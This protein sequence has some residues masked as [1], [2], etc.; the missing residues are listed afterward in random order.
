MGQNLCVG[1]PELK[2]KVKYDENMPRKQKKYKINSNLKSMT[3]QENSQ[4][5]WAF[6]YEEVE[7]QLQV[8]KN[9][10]NIKSDCLII[11]QDKELKFQ[12]KANQ[13]ILKKGGQN[14]KEEL[15]EFQLK[16]KQK[17]IHIGQVIK[18]HAGNLDCDYL[19][20]LILPD[21]SKKS[22]KQLILWAIQN[23]F[24]EAIKELNLMSL[25]IPFIQSNEKDEIDNQINAN[26]M[27]KAI[28]NYIDEFI[29][30]NFK[31]GQ[32]ISKRKIIIICENQEILQILKLGY[33]D[34]FQNQKQVNLKKSFRK[35]EMKKSTSD[36]NF[37][38]HYEKDTIRIYGDPISKNLINRLNQENK[39]TQR[40]AHS[41]LS[42]F[43]VFDSNQDLFQQK[44]IV[45]IKNP[46]K[47]KFFQQ[48]QKS[49]SN[50][51][52]LSNLEQSIQDENKSESI[53]KENQNFNSCQEYQ[54]EQIGDYTFNENNQ[55]K[56]FPQ[57]QYQY[58]NQLQNNNQNQQNDNKQNNDNIILNTQFGEKNQYKNYNQNNQFNKQ[59]QSEFDEKNEPYLEDEQYQ[60]F[61]EISDQL[62]CDKNN[63]EFIKAR[64]INDILIEQEKQDSQKGD[65]LNED[66]FSSDTTIY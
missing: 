58:V 12:G 54:S 29:V 64:R 65:T 38:N 42:K 34:V 21:L 33:Q 23:L 36:N 52:N 59:Y 55:Y 47:S 17:V 60:E 30:K 44:N 14:I 62:Q 45:Q 53:I 6:L 37:M 9:V 63:I 43:E 31:K 15:K 27:M 61:K 2:L 13:E 25:A 46:Q 1:D 5:Q 41:Q 51:D 22:N 8:I 19:L 50:I 4:N 39:N 3:E 18:T 48:K 26:F 49:K 28:K 35:R 20:H 10:A 7:I 66:S 32:T 24:D 11:L 57:C 56:N 16:K 40:M